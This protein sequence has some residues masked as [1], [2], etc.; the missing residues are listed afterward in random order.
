MAFLLRYQRRK[1]PDQALD[2][3]PARL[4]S[5][6][7]PLLAILRLSVALARSRS[8]ADLPDFSLDA[9][10]HGRLVLALP[11]GWVQSRPLSARS[12]EI[13]RRQVR[14]V[15]IRLERTILD[16]PHPERRSPAP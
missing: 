6:A 1:L 8:D 9:P 15:G 11:E 3:L 5:A 16:A 14:S 13:E 10:D 12:L 2:E 4:R 7:A